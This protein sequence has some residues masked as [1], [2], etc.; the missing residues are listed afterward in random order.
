MSTGVGSTP[1]LF[2]DNTYDALGV[3]RNPDIRANADPDRYDLGL[4]GPTRV[5]LADRNDLCGAFRVPSLRNVAKT[6]PYFHN[7]AIKTLAD[8]VRFYVRRDTN[9]EEWYPTDTNGVVQKFNDLPPAYRKNVNTTEVPYNRKPG[10]NPALTEAEI[11]DVVAFLNTLTD[12][13]TP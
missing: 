2:T 9:P 11:A 13:Y 5:D 10:D 12:G 7:G 1:P 3:P 4:C 6:A 8:A